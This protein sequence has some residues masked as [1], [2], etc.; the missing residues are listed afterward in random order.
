MNFAGQWRDGDFACSGTSV[1]HLWGHHISEAEIAVAGEG[2]RDWL[3]SLLIIN[4]EH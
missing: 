3:T 4:K 1:R 2:Y